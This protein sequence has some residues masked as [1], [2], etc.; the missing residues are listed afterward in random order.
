MIAD[1]MAAHDWPTNGHL[2]WDLVRLGYLNAEDYTLDT[3]YGRGVW[4]KLWQPKRLLTN[5]WTDDPSQPPT[6]P[7]TAGSRR[8]GPHPPPRRPR[9]RAPHHRPQAAPRPRILT[10][11]GHP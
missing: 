6:N 11:T 1:V 5:G 10:T 2:I 4:W 3:T 9:G 7:A 8:H